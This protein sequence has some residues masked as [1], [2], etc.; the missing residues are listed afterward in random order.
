VMPFHGASDLDTYAHRNGDD[1]S[2]EYCECGRDYARDCQC[3]TDSDQPTPER[4]AERE[5]SADEMTRAVFAALAKV[6]ARRRAEQYP[7]GA[8]PAP[9]E[10]D[11]QITTALAKREGAQE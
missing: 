2:D 4:D 5:L 1:G 9:A 7:D 10:T 3:L 6:S 8:Y 11:E